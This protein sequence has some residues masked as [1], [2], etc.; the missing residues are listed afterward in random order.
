MDKTC[1]NCFSYVRALGKIA[2]CINCTI[3]THSNWK[4]VPMEESKP[5]EELKNDIV[6]YC[7]SNMYE[8]F[9]CVINDSTKEDCKMCIKRKFE[10]TDKQMDELY[11]VPQ[12]LHFNP[13]CDII[14]PITAR[15]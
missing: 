13:I 10:L 2:D 7:Q 3:T 11:P 9:S 15:V 1:E 4:P 8:E 12:N 14:N 5:I 6:S